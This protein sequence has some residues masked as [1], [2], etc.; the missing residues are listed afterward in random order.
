MNIAY[1]LNFFG[2]F[3]WGISI[4]NFLDQ[5]L[6]A[7]FDFKNINSFLS[8]VTAILALFFA[9]YKLKAYIRDSKTK[10]KILEEELF[11]R[12]NNNFYNKFNKEFDDNN[13]TSN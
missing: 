13:S 10:S 8:M 4:T 1:T 2:Y 11:E 3:L 6:N 9:F 7:T 5:L 12:Q